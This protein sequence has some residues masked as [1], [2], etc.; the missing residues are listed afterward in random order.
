MT[1]QALPKIVSKA[2]WRAAH[3]ALLAKEKE[4]T[5]ARDALAAQ[6]RRLPAMRIE[7]NYR[8]D[9]PDG[10]VSLLDLFE[11]RSQLITYYFMF[12]PGVDGW[13]SA[14]CPGCSMFTDNIGQFTLTHLANRDVSF[15][16]ISRGP[17]QNLLAYKKRMSWTAPWVSSEHTTFHDDLELKAADGE[18]HQINVFI[19][20]GKDI[21]RT[22][23]SQAR[24]CEAVGNIWGFLDITPYGRQETWEDS[25]EGW[26]QTPPYEWWRRH[27]DY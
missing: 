18:R 22:Y 12:A 9:G 5:R 24:G 15:S 23:S 26:P 17:L 13:P 1:A 2:E 25:P 3:D 19:R 6:R 16:L 14:G 10:K 27:D 4:M 8:F 20:E 11:G 21:Y 7:Q